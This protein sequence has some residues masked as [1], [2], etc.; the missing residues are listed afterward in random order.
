MVGADHAAYTERFHELAR[1]VP[2]LVTLESRKI[3]RFVYGLALQIRRMVAAMEPKTIQKVVQISGALT[4][5]AVRNGSNKKV[6][7]RGNMGEP[8][9][10]KNS[11]DDN[12]RIRIRNAFSTTTNPVGRENTGTCPKCTTYNPYHAPGGPCHTCFNCN[13]PGYLANDFR[14]VPRNVNPVNARNPTIMACFECGGTDHVR[15]R[16][17]G[18]QGNQ[19]RGRAFML[20]AEEARQDLNIVTGFKYEIKIASGQLV[21]IDMVIKGCKLEIEGHVF[22]IDLIP[23]GPG[24]CDVIIGMDWLSN[25]KAEI[26]CHEKVVGIPLSDGKVLRVLEERPEEKARFL[27]SAKAGDKKQEEIVVV[28]DFPKGEEQEFAFQTLKDKLCNAP[29]LAL[30]DGPKDFMVYCDAFGIG[31][32]CV[33]MQR[34]KIELFSDYDCKI[35]YHPGKANVVD[36]ALSRK[37]RVKPKIVRAMNMTLQLSVK[38]RILSA[39]KEAVDEFVGLQKGLDEMIE[40]RSDGNLYCLDRIWVPLKGDVRTLIIDEAYKSK[41]SVHLGADKMY[42]YSVRCAPFAAF[43][44]RKRR[45]PIMWAEVGEGHMAYRLY[46]PEELNGVH[47]TFHLLNLKKCLADP[48]LVPLD[49]IR[50]HAKLNFM[51]WP[52]GILE[53]EFKKLKH[54]RI[55]IVKPQRVSVWEGAEDFVRLQAQEIKL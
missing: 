29:I 50:V 44:G 38:D 23:F 27:M 9:K 26:I 4:D 42:H 28:R 16:G 15:G 11:R 39:Q 52:V 19:A 32:G 3:K 6:E 36:D 53:R 40:Q 33:L 34:G 17:R 43:Y 25:Y 10:D 1:L 51:E 30:P 47:D 41:Y 46:L 31:L 7:K 12:K 48:T 20:G 49:E 54:N 14:G 13:H 55:A 37:E 21:E 5:E 45:S 2:H 18:N 35:R 8:S 24:S 22:D